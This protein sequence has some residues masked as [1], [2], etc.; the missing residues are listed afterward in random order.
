MHQRF[1][2]AEADAFR[3]VHGEAEVAGQLEALRRFAARAASVGSPA[4]AERLHGELLDFRKGLAP[5]DAYDLAV[6]RA[7]DGLGLDLLLFCE[8]YAEGRPD[9]A[10]ELLR[11][12]ADRLGAAASLPP[13]ARWLP[14]GPT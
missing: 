3:P 7:V 12:V 11:S 5:D 14:T 13:G 2:R 1:T 10:R 9:F 8:H 4:E 6:D